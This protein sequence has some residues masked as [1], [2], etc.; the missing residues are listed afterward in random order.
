MTAIRRWIDSLPRRESITCLSVGASKIERVDTK[1]QRMLSFV[2]AGSV[3][4]PEPKTTPAEAADDLTG[5]A[6]GT[7]CAAG[8]TDGNSRAQ[9][10]PTAAMDAMVPPEPQEADSASFALEGVE[11]F[12]LSNVDASQQLHRRLGASSYREDVSDAS[13]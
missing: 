1:R 9:L 10:T 11:A 3:P 6:A 8:A 12:A 5:G 4:K 2:P 13:G 7:V